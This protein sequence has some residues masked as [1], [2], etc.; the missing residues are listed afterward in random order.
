MAD[1]RVIGVCKHQSLEAIEA[2]IELGVRALGNNYIQEGQALM[3]S[4]ASRAPLEWHF[5]GHIQS[6]KVQDLLDYDWV[7]SLDRLK[8]VRALNDTLL[9]QGK[10]IQGLV[11]VNIGEEAQKSGVLPKDI[12]NFVSEVSAFK[13]IRLRGL[14]ALPPPL[15]PVERRAPFFEQMKSIF[16]GYQSSHGW[17]TLSMGTSDDYWVALK[18]G[19]NMVRLGTCLYGSR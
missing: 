3:A 16:D 19:A 1:I 5:I 12:A 2:G 13:A 9:E 4:L 10:V 15:D 6:R 18:C 11:Q 17:D 14:M 8:V 7:Q